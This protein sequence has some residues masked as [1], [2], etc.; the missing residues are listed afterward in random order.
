MSTYRQI[1][2]SVVR[3]FLNKEHLTWL[4]VI[5]DGLCLFRS[6]EV[7]LK[8]QGIKTYTYRSLKTMVKEFRQF[9]SNSLQISTFDVPHIF[10]LGNCHAMPWFVTKLSRTGLIISHSAL[11]VKNALHRGFG[12]VY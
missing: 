8:H 4:P 5:G 9:N 2:S 6:V 3:D 11:R 7:S 12:C 10:S 1:T